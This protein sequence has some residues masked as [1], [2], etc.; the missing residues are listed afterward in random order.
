MNSRQTVFPT[1]NSILHTDTLQESQI[2]ITTKHKHYGKHKN[3]LDALNFVKSNN[4]NVKSFSQRRNSENNNILN[5]INSQLNSTT[6]G[7]NVSEFSLANAY[8]SREE[9]VT[10]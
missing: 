4:N 5:T 3:F 8:V 1:N 6:E 10:K 7:L 9:N 2:S